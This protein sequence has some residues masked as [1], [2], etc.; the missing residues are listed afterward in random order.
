MDLKV[1]PGMAYARALALRAQVGA[2]SC[3]VFADGVRI[4]N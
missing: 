1:Y 2:R 4:L 3:S